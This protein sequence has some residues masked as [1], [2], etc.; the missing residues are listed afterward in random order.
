MVLILPA[1]DD[2]GHENHLLLYSF[3][4]AQ[5]NYQ[6]EADYSVEVSSC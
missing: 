6:A 3:K 1:T 5:V 2:K 4:P